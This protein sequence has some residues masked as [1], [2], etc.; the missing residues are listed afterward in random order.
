MLKHIATLAV[1]SAIVLCMESPTAISRQWR[2]TQ[3]NLAQD[4]ATIQD[5][6]PDGEIVF[7]IWLAFPMTGPDA[8][9]DFIE[10]LHRYT[11]I[12]AVHGRM[13]TDSSGIAFEH[14]ESLASK[15]RDGKALTPTLKEDIPA[16]YSSFLSN[17]EASMKATLGAFGDSA[18]L[19]VFDGR[20]VDAC[21]SGGL[22]VFLANETYTWET[23]F[24]GCSQK[25]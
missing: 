21:A 11:I 13:A 9:A 5:V 4:Y 3:Q 2:P 6:R 19:F 22:S 14:I 24:P 12:F 8:P 7:L 20:D 23:P 10:M 1:A 15:N 18:Q 25:K 16:R 17:A